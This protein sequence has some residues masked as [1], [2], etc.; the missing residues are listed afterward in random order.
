MDHIL[1]FPC[2]VARF[3][4]NIQAPKRFSVVGDSNS[5][6]ALDNV[7]HHRSI[8]KPR[9]SVGVWVTSSTLSTTTKQ[10]AFVVEDEPLMSPSEMHDHH[11]QTKGGMIRFVISFLALCMY[12]RKKENVCKHITHWWTRIDHY[13]NTMYKFHLNRRVFEKSSSHLFVVVCYICPLTTRI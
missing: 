5:H 7:T 4:S 10:Q 9:K 2:K 3:V 11:Y 8:A 1:Q 12:G 13:C 6:S